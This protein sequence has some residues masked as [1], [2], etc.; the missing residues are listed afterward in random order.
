MSTC[1]QYQIAGIQVGN[2]YRSID[3]GVT[4]TPTTTTVTNI[5]NTSMYT[6]KYQLCVS[7]VTFTYTLYYSSTYGVYWTQLSSAPTNIFAPLPIAISASGQYQSAAEYGGRIYYSNNYGTTWTQ[8]S[9]SITA[10][11][12]SLCMSSSGKYQMASISGGSIYYSSNYGVSWIPTSLANA[13]WITVCMS[14]N[15]QYASANIQSSY[16][17]RSVVPYQTLATNTISLQNTAT[18]TTT[19]SGSLYITDGGF[20]STSGTNTYY[21]LYGSSSL[22]GQDFYGTMTWNNIASSPVY[23][24]TT[25]KILTLL[26]SGLNFETNK[27]LSFN[28]SIYISGGNGNLSG[29]IVIGNSTSGSVLIGAGQNNTIIGSGAGGALTSGSVNVSVGQNAGQNITTGIGNTAVGAGALS[30][31]TI[32]GSYNTAVGINAGT[33]ITSGYSNLILGWGSNISAGGNNNEIVIG[34]GATGKGSNTTTIQSAGS[35]TYFI[36]GSGGSNNVIMN[37]RP[38]GLDILG[39]QTNPRWLA[40]ASFNNGNAWRMT[41]VDVGSGVFRLNFAN[42]GGNTFYLVSNGTAGLIT[43][44]DVRFKKNISTLP[45]SL[46]KLLAL[47][48][49]N[50]LYSNEPDDVLLNAGFIAQE[51]AQIIPHIVEDSDPKKLG[52]DYTSFIPYIVK[53][54]QE[55]HAEITELKDTISDLKAQLTS[56]KAIVD[57]LTQKP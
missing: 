20:G 41:N 11:W 48:P 50:F 56:L 35:Y 33:S 18:P 43:T 13:N 25:D 21:R 42:T 39:D 24:S 6:G 53:G 2:L 46:E 27:K 31:T 15:G 17:W 4:W 34:I 28:S 47:H 36:N 54:I 30:T 52:V 45:S 57:K 23:N 1:G 38:E 32:S 22:V 7:L 29:N 55:Q 3:Y 44:S 5:H 26:S 14:S 49:V 51:V 16:I 10:N 40:L 19:A 8:S 37:T 9:N 12:N